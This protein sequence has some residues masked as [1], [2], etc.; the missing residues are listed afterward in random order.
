VEICGVWAI[1]LGVEVSYMDVDHW[2]R[3]FF[4]KMMHIF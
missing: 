2:V 1:G 3:V 4:L